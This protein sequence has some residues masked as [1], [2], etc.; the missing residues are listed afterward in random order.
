MKPCGEDRS[1]AAA[2]YS[3]NATSCKCLVRL[4]KS[5]QEAFYDLCL[6]SSAPPGR[7]PS[8]WLIAW[9]SAR[10]SCRNSMTHSLQVAARSR[11]VSCA[12]DSGVVCST[13]VCI[14]RCRSTRLMILIIRMAN[15]ICFL[16]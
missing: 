10:R 15:H 6:G 5:E 2:R 8:R 12:C 16:F 14:D 11:E 9:Y 3:L 1:E 13:A 4:A 7:Q